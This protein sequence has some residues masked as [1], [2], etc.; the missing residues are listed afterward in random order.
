MDLLLFMKH[1]LGKNDDATNKEQI[2]VHGWTKFLSHIFLRWDWSFIHQNWSNSSLSWDWSNT[3][4]E[5]KWTINEKLIFFVL[6]SMFET[7]VGIDED[8]NKQ[9]LKR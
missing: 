5:M 1:P 4:K 7:E 2:K 9:E 8:R 3:Y 6:V